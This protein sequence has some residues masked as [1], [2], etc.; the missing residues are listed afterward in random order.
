MRDFQSPVIKH[1]DQSRLSIV[2][3]SSPKMNSS[4]NKQRY[5]LDAGPDDAS[6]TS[7]TIDKFASALEPW[8]DYLFGSILVLIGQYHC[9]YRYIE[10]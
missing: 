6:Y 5:E 8:G 3:Y 1:L 7:I 9:D 10:S 4:S 2:A